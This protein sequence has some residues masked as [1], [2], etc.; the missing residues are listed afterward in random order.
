M[1]VQEARSHGAPGAMEG[2]ARRRARSRLL[3]GL[4]VWCLLLLVLLGLI[5]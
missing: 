3:L 4:V 1:T 2:Y 5:R